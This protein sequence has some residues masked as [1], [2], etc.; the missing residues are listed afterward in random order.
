M[1][2]WKEEVV[3]IQEEMCCLIAYHEWKAQWWQCQL[4][5][6]SDTDNSMIHGVAAYAE[7]EVVTPVISAVADKDLEDEVS[8]VIGDKEGDGSEIDFFEID[9]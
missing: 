3:L 2:H 7:K 6:H 8:E 1:Q 9:Y 5:H 4:A